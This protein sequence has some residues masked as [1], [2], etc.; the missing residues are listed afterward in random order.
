MN[1]MAARAV[2]AWPQSRGARARPSLATRAGW[3]SRSILGPFSAA[4]RCAGMLLTLFVLAP[5][6][7][8]LHVRGWSCAGASELINKSRTP[9]WVVLKAPEL[10]PRP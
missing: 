5:M 6:G 7:F 8:F 2:G 1:A 4:S 3:S 9:L 10:A